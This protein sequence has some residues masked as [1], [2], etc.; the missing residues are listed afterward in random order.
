[1]GAKMARLGL[2]Y[3]DTTS[4]G[5]LADTRKRRLWGDKPRRE[6]AVVVKSA[7]SSEAGRLSSIMATRGNRKRVLMI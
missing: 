5:E 3:H 2:K 6:E 4:S 7:R 1:M